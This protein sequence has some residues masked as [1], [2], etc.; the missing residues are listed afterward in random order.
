MTHLSVVVG[1][2]NGSE[3]KGTVAGWLCRPQAGTVVSVRVGGPN[4]GHTIYGHCPPNCNLSTHGPLP[5]HQPENERHPWKLRQ[6]PVAAVTNPTAVLILAEG[7][8]V[9]PLVL[10]DEVTSL[11]AA[12]YRVSER[13]YIDPQATILESRHIGD[14]IRDR[15]T[16]RLGSTAKGI[17]AARADRLWR[18]ARLA[19]DNGSWIRWTQVSTAQMMNEGMGSNVHIVIE[20]TQGYD[21]GLHAG[22]YPYCTAGNARSIDFMAQA[23]LSPWRSG[24]TTRTW[25]VARTRPIRVAGNSGPMKGETSWEELGLAEERTT[26]TNKVRRVGE[27]DVDQLRRAISANGGVGPNLRVALLMADYSFPDLYGVKSSVDLS[28]AETIELDNWVF[29]REREIGTEIGFLGTSPVTHF[30]RSHLDTI[31][32]DARLYR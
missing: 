10:H 26:V 17:G 28:T 20:G 32:R 1:G 12:G 14:E 21:L 22:N 8:E 11:D 9:D 7:S 23:G 31:R 27:Y 30:D 19:K 3:G 6:I 18:Y 24:W 5:D 4:A 16:E 29:D 13:L 15:I 25:V 2:Q